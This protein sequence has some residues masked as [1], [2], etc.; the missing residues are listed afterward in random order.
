M[1]TQ[2]FGQVKEAEVDAL[3]ARTKNRPMAQGRI[4]SKQACFIGTGLTVSSL[5]AYQVSILIFVFNLF[6]VNN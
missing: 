1:S 2:C 6:N 3:M 4:S 5:M